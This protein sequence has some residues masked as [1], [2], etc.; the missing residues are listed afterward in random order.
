MGRWFAR[1]L[2]S[3]GYRIDI[4]DPSGAVD[5]Y[6]YVEDWP[7]A[8]SQYDLIVV[9]TS[10]GQTSDV[11]NRLAQAQPNGLVVEITSLKTPRRK[12]LN[13]LVDAGV[14]VASIH[15]MFGPSTE[16]LSGRHVVCVDLGV[17]SAHALGQALFDSTMARCVT[18]SLDEHDRVIAQVLGLS[19]AINIAFFTALA[20]CG[21]SVPDL[22]Q[23]SSTTFDAQLNVSAAVSR[24]NPELYYDIQTK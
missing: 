11:L 21:A 1:F 4:A 22:A 24:E 16:L 14:R 9:S 19:H 3:Q 6:G 7:S 8:V 12:S 23:I 15:P 20:R 18:M 17:Q 10:L 13:N 2:A 5:G